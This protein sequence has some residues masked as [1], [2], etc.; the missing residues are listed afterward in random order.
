MESFLVHHIV[1]VLLFL[2][3]LSWLNRSNGFFYFLSLIYLYLVHERY[4]MRLK[5]QLQFEERKQA[6]QRRVLTDSESVRWLNHAVEKI[7]PICMEQI[8]SEKILGPIIPWFLDKYRPW[9]AKKAVIQHLYMGKKPPLLTDIRV[10]RQSKSDDH[11]V[12]EL[13]MN[14]LA[15]DD[16]SAILAVKLRKRL[17]F[18]MWTKLH[19]TGMQVE[20][21]VLVGVKF[22]RR[23][24]FLGRLRVCFA[25][26]PYFQMTVKPI[27]THGLDVAVLPGIAGWLDKLLSIA[28]EQTLVQP[29]MLVVDMEKFV[30]PKPENWF[31]VD[32]K[33]PVAH[34]LVEVVE[35]SD[36][37]PS[38]LNG[39]AD[40]YVRGKLGAY[41]FKTDIKRKT[42]SPTWQEEFKIP[43]FTWDSPSILNVEVKDKDRFVDDT[44][45]A[46]SVNIGE[47]RGGQ[48]NDMWLPLQNIKMGRLHL[49]I[50]VIEDSEKW[51][52]DPFKGVKLSKED[53]QTSFASDTTNKGSFTSVSSEKAS[54][55]ADNVEP[56]NI[57][58][59][60]D[61]GIWVQ[62]PGPEVSQIWEPRKGKSRRVDNQVQRVSNNGSPNNE[63]SSSTDE[64]QEGS[65]NPMK[66]VGRGL[67][68]IGSVF[69]RNN[70]KKD[71]FSIGSIEEDSHC[72]SP[73]I[74]VKAMNQKDVGVKYIVDDNLSGPL[75]G[76][77]VESES[78]N[79]EENHGKG[80]MKDVAKSF[81]KQAEKSAKQ[82]KHVFSLKGIKKARD[83]QHEII[84]ESDS[85]TDSDSSSDDDDDE[86]TCVQKVGKVAGTPRGL[87]RDGN[88]VRTGDEDYIDTNKTLAEEAKEDP[89]ADIADSSWDAEAKE[90]KVEEA[91][92]KTTGVDVAM[93][94]KTEDE[95]VVT[96]KNIEGE[97]KE[98]SE[99][100]L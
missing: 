28:F 65:R 29:N 12:L 24:P 25:E 90:E 46:C 44:L 92:S 39:L 54:S 41:R 72:Q 43:I 52:E 59:Q 48:R 82:F 5:R 1:I 95:H 75:T 89:S 27:F 49:A 80:H 62:R 71:D 45:G 96:A 94:A 34:V 58:G 91:D 17:G 6:N 98:V 40:P 87:T 38:D 51:S 10:L 16:M 22:L 67:R 53:I 14:F 61:T 93:N 20:G 35:A 83:G 31:F 81:L 36:V 85:V 19:L 8:A 69:N 15:A 63:T 42:L 7:W 88:I 57:K 18:G 11:L 33:E 100:K 70:N 60:E 84:P 55:V 26:P 78:M 56:I 66:S 74:N 37:K 79:G 77:S 73:R 86:Y 23:W 21:K 32:E 97:E 68:K 13:G 99:V 4:V 50:T 64:N 3:F 30:S 2:W 9:T 76:K 47:F